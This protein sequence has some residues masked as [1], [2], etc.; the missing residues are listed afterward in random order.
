MTRRRTITGIALLVLLA[1]PGALQAQTKTTS[2]KTTKGSVH[3]QS[4]RMTGVVDWI[5]GTTLVVKMRP[6]GEYRVFVVP[7]D[8]QFDIDG[9]IKHIGDIKRG[10]VL[11]ATVMTTTQ[12]MTVRTTSELTGTVAWVQG[13]YVVLTHENGENHEYHVP[14]SFKFVVNGKPASVSEL[15][16]GMKVSATKIV[17]EPH[18][19]ISSNTT[20]T[21]TSPK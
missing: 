9:Q 10:T 16:E 15:R 14:A 18:T 17:E 1:A 4:T 20:I 2:T 19:E 12:P 21:G 8:R 6:H 7:P 3:V 11:T 5:Q 13:N